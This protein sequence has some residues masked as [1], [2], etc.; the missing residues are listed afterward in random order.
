MSN[1]PPGPLPSGSRRY[2]VRLTRR[3][4]IGV[5]VLVL[6]IVAF[7]IG[8]GRPMYR[9][10]VAI[11]V[12]ERAGGHVRGAHAPNSSMFG[13]AL[14]AIPAIFDAIETVELSNSQTTDTDL[15][16]LNR[17]PVCYLHLDGTSITDAG[18]VHLR[19]LT[20]LSWIKLDDTRVTDAGLAHLEGLTRLD[21]LYLNNT[22]VTDAGL[23]R[24]EKLT[25]LRCLELD[26]CQVT[27]GGLK[28][29]KGL[30]RL[31]VLSL[32][33]TGVT[34]ECFTHLRE[35]DFV[36]LDL[37]YTKITAAGLAQMRLNRMLRLRLDGLP[38][39]DVI[40][41]KLKNATN[42]RNVSLVSTQ[43]TGPGVAELQRALPGLSI[44][45]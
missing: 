43:V 17:L 44:D 24:L 27:D 35:H 26:N 34:D 33:G 2:T 36:V 31:E 7:G 19:D 37:S 10:Q 20:R 25:N 4:R 3:K 5:T 16:F 6:V 22:R 29:L 18:L 28:H 13:S 23:E 45:K 38:V 15:A 11:N 39:T 12:I 21:T 1:A 9:K 8:V 30:G 14:P 41:A 40:L 32:R 42:L